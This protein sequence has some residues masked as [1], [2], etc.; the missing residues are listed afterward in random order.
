MNSLEKVIQQLETAY[1]ARTQKYIHLQKDIT[2][3]SKE[4]ETLTEDH[5]SLA[6]QLDLITSRLDEKSKVLELYEEGHRRS[7][8]EIRDLQNKL[9]QANLDSLC[10]Q[11]LFEEINDD[12][13]RVKVNLDKTESILGIV[14]SFSV[15]TT[16]GLLITIWSIYHGY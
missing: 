10:S 1:E 16:A 5:T 2:T 15:T 14:I 13:Q 3:L 9:N 11:R 4:N 8:E 6:K 7:Q 12:F